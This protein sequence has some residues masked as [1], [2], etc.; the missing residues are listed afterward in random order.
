MIELL[1]TEEIME[2]SGG[3]TSK[4]KPDEW[5]ESEENYEKHDVNKIQVL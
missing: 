4:C 1:I 5:K 3:D 2:L